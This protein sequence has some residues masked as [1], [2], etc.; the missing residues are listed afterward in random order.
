MQFTLL[1]AA[2]VLLLNGCKTISESP[3]LAETVNTMQPM[4]SLVLP[5]KWTP[6]KNIFVW[7]DLQFVSPATNRMIPEFSAVVSQIALIC[8][9]CRRERLPAAQ[10]SASFDRLAPIAS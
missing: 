7:D 4:S 3:V 10:T 5:E 9:S 8:R 2:F 1:I 6:I